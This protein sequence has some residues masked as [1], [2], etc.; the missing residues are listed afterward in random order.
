M[1]ATPQATLV[2]QR[3]ARRGEG[4]REEDDAAGGAHRHGAGPGR[5]R[6]SV[7][8][9]A[10]ASR[11]AARSTPPPTRPGSTASRPGS[12]TAR[13]SSSS[14]PTAWASSREP[15]H[16]APPG[17]ALPTLVPDPTVTDSAGNTVNAPSRTPPPLRAAQ[18]RGRHSL[19]VARPG[20]LGLPRRHAQRLAERR[21]SLDRPLQARAF[22]ARR[23][24]TSTSRTTSSRAT[25]PYSAPGSRSAW[26]RHLGH[27]GVDFGGC[28]NQYWNGGPLPSLIAQLFGEWNG[29]PLD[30][31]SLWSDTTDNAVPQYLGHQ[32]ALRAHAGHDHSHRSFRHRHE[33]QRKRPAQRR[34]F[35]AAPYDQSATRHAAH[36]RQLVQPARR[37]PRPAP[38]GQHRRRAARRLPLGEDARRVRRPLRLR[39]GTKPPRAWDYTQY[40]PW[41]V[42]GDGTEPLGI[43]SGAWSTPPRASGSRSRRCSS[44]RTRRRRCSDRGQEAGA[45]RPRSPVGGGLGF[46]FLRT[47]RSSCAVR[48]RKRQFGRS[49]LI[50]AYQVSPIQS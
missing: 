20:R 26:L 37:R 39:R 50:A 29:S 9:T 36:Q 41:N 46:F 48:D 43:R 33:P 18:L 8:A 27:A 45:S 12:A 19:A 24:S 16:S 11:R 34:P 35:A 4:S 15:A 32:P 47:A 42:T 21:R 10:A 44:R 30:P 28:P 31:N 1:E 14:S 6:H 25:S 22:S 5:L 3:H 7:S 38:D 13:R 2:H 23:A 17:P 49:P 40:N